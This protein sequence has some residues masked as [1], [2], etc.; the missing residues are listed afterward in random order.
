MI[1]ERIH[2]KNNRRTS[3]LHLI[4]ISSSLGHPLSHLATRRLTAPPTL[5]LAAFSVRCQTNGFATLYKGV[6]MSEPGRQG[7]G[8]HCMI[9]VT[10]YLLVSR[11]DSKVNNNLRWSLLG[12]DSISG[13]YKWSKWKAGQVQASTRSSED[14]SCGLGVM[15]AIKESDSRSEKRFPSQQ[16]PLGPPK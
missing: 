13:L 2:S 15:S 4:Y 10:R 7:S 5:K 1:H 14:I 8:G 11:A 3:H 6:V 9:R 16:N 12:S